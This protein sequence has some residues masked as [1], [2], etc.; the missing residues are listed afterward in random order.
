VN[1]R[2]LFVVADGEFD[3][4]ALQEALDQ[5]ATNERYLQREIEILDLRDFFPVRNELAELIR[6]M[7]DEAALVRANINH[8]RSLNRQA[9]GRQIRARAVHSPRPVAPTRERRRTCSQS[10]RWMVTR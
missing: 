2:P 9:N 6:E 8:F 10:S 1:D 4:H 7:R 5:F 3:L